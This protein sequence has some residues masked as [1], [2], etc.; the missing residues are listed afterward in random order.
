MGIYIKGME[1][2]EHCLYCPFNSCMKCT[3]NNHKNVDKS[4]NTKERDK[5]CPLIYVQSHGD[6]IDRNYLKQTHCA[7]CTLYPGNCLEKSGEECDWESIAHLYMCPV[8]IPAEEG[9]T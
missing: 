1:L 7:E 6:L 8:V 2:P 5:E 3:L 9:E 4:W